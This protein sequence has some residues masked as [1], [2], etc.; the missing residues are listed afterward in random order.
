MNKKGFTIIE[1]IISISLLVVITIIVI[2]SIQK[3]N[4]KS[5]EKLYNYVSN[6]VV[7]AHESNKKNEEYL[8]K[9]YGYYV[10][11]VDELK[12][13]GIIDEKTLN[14]YINELEE[15]SNLVDYTKAVLV[16][17]YVDNGIVDV[18]YPYQENKMLLL[19]ELDEAYVYYKGNEYH[20][21]KCSDFLTKPTYF[22]KNYT[23]NELNNFENLKCR[24]SICDSDICSNTLE[25]SES[26]SDK[27]SL[28]TNKNIYYLDYEYRDLDNNV[29][30]NYLKY[31]NKNKESLFTYMPRIINLINLDNIKIKA[32]DKNKNEITDY[33]SW[34]K[35]PTIVVYN[36]NEELVLDN[37]T[38]GNLVF[39]GSVEHSFD[40][41]SVMLDSIDY[42][43][44]YSIKFKLQ[45]LEYNSLNNIKIDNSIPIITSSTLNRS[46]SNYEYSIKVTDENSGIKS[47]AL[48][49][50]KSKKES[51]T[52]YI[53]N[54]NRTFTLDS[55]YTKYSIV[56]EDNAGN[57]VTKSLSDEVMVSVTAV[58]DTLFK[59][60]ISASNIKSINIKFD[61]NN[62]LSTEQNG[63]LSK[64]NVSKSVNEY[65]N[66]FDLYE[67]LTTLKDTI[68]S[69]F[70]SKPEFNI[71]IEVK[72]KNN[73][74]KKY[75]YKIGYDW[76]DK[77]LLYTTQ[78][79]D[80]QNNAIYVNNNNDIV[81]QHQRNASGYV[82]YYNYTNFYRFPNF[83]RETITP[84]ETE[85]KSYAEVVYKFD[86]KEVRVLTISR[87]NDDNDKYFDTVYNLMTKNISQTYLGKCN[88]RRCKTVFVEEDPKLT[89]IDNKRYTCDFNLFKDEY[90]KYLTLLA[91]SQYHYKGDYFTQKNYCIYN[92]GY[93][94]KLLNFR[95][96]EAKTR[97]LHMLKFKVGLD[98][99]L[100]R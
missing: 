36:N 29:Y 32:F 83:D 84:V 15:K 51:F 67:L 66:T 57:I 22:D 39:S 92:N 38:K 100:D 7:V 88:S 82:P 28:S 81:V 97:D 71:K 64:Y 26:F 33:N 4:K 9:N 44:E 14:N 59:F 23:K 61:E 3:N 53:K 80:H 60:N 8:K 16:K 6:S 96:A 74:A 78:N 12:K 87:Y 1:I 98:I 62:K 41:S 17:D 45:D 58:D 35:S 13:L 56:I 86:T 34:Y 18:I 73:K 69:D 37:N 52:S 27:I 68:R 75:S 93:Y 79:W 25:N 42:T 11:S 85:K 19:D 5:D 63:L 48:S 2:I 90:N 24:V 70:V 65:S 31:D 95:D 55:N 54:I 77:E 30:H 46:G 99:K 10:Y 94:Y 20:E 89:L 21:F 49:G 43:G 72:D 40:V 91:Y 47:I 50:P 76:M